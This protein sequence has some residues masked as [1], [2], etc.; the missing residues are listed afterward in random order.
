M[1][2]GNIKTEFYSLN[3]RSGVLCGLPHPRIQ[4]SLPVNMFKLSNYDTRN[5]CLLVLGNLVGEKASKQST[6]ATKIVA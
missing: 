1:A 6:K 4:R 3:S 5:S 2:D